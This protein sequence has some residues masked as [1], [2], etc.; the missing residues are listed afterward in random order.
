MKIIWNYLIFNKIYANEYERF[1]SQCECL[2]SLR[3]KYHFF[4]PFSLFI[5]EIIVWIENKKKKKSKLLFWNNTYSICF[6]DSLLILSDSLSNPAPPCPKQFNLMKFQEKKER[7]RKYVFQGSLR[8]FQHLGRKENLIR[9]LLLIFS[10]SILHSK[11]ITFTFN[12]AVSG[13]IW[14]FLVRLYLGN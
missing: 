10:A 2:S 12:L 14:R 11:L 8:L 3:K 9:W 6:C 5:R 13:L 4:P 1:V 7:E